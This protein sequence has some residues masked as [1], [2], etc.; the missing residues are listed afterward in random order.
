MLERNIEMRYRNLLGNEKT[1]ELLDK[2][3][4]QYCKQEF[5]KLVMGPMDSNLGNTAL[6]LTNNGNPETPD[7]DISPAYDLDLSFNVAKE[8]SASQ[9]MDLLKTGDGQMANINSFIQE[10]KDLL[11]FKEFLTEFYEKIE[12]RHAANE[13][14]ADAYQRTNFKF[15]Y[16]NDEKYLSFLNQ[17]FEQV[18]NAYRECYT[19]GKGDEENEAI[20][21]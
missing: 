2:L 14:V 18:R 13:I 6:I 3:R 7:I 5:M 9:K 17:R 21:E 10:F 11:G 20:L 4:L 8:L 1:K 12:S 19:N 15:F 16:E